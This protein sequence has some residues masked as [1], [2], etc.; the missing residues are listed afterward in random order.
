MCHARAR[1]PFPSKSGL[2]PKVLPVG[3]PAIASSKRNK[4]RDRPDQRRMR[5]VTGP[6]RFQRLQRRLAEGGID[7]RGVRRSATAIGEGKQPPRWTAR[8][9][10][11]HRRSCGQHYLTVPTADASLYQRRAGDGEASQSACVSAF[12]RP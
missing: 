2:R 5:H 8:P 9:T 6:R 4:A 3:W 10:N 1:S 7:R 11:F 12:H